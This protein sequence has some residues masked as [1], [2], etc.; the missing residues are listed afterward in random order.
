VAGFEVTGDMALSFCSIGLISRS[1]SSS[2]SL[3]MF[4]LLVMSSQRA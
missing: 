1:Y 2:A 4:S 3:T